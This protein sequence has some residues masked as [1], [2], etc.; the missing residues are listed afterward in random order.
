MY[1]VIA[2][3]FV[4]VIAWLYFTRDSGARISPDERKEL[5]KA[6]GAH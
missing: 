3:A 4:A 2:L 6:R 5:E 1:I